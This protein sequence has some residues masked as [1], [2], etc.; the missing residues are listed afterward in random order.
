MAYKSYIKMWESEFDNFLSKR[1][2]FQDMN[3]NQLQPELHDTYKKVE[4][5]TNFEAINNEDVINKAFL[6]DKMLTKLS[7]SFLRKRI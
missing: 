3:I 4:K 7:L 1:D 5:T 2:N 6:D